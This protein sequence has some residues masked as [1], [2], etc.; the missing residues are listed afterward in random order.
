MVSKVF[1][2]DKQT[3]LYCSNVAY[4][5]GVWTGW[6][7]NG[8]WYLHFN[9]T[10]GILKV[11]IDRRSLK[12]PVTVSKAKLT[13]ACDPFKSLFDYR[14]VIVDAEARYKVGEHANYK[15]TKKKKSV[16]ED[17]DDEVPF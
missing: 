4:K 12:N 1:L 10:T 5:D 2:F 3:W 17:Y 13:W 14:S 9:E 6:V 11:C 16:K 8:A 7:E 15:L